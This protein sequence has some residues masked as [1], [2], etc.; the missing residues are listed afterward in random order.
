MK[1][2]LA[3]IA[4]N[5]ERYIER[6]L[7]SF[8]PHFDEVVIVRACGSLPPDRTLEIAAERGCVVGEYH[9]AEQG[10]DWPHVDDFAAARNVSFNLASGDWIMWTD[11][12]DLIDVKSMASIK[13][14]L[15][16]MPDDRDALEVAYEVPE[17]GVTVFRERVI[18][19]GAAKWVSPI[20]EHLQFPGE[21]RLA[22]ITDAK[23]VHH[24]IGARRSNDERNLR[25]LES[26][27][28]DERTASHRFHLFQSL[29]VCDRVD[30]AIAEAVDLLSGPP[31]GIGRAERFE[32]FIAVGQLSP[33]IETRSNMI[34]QALGTDPTRREAF[35]EMALCRIAAG[36]PKSALGFSRCMRAIDPPANRAWNTRGKYYGWL[37][38]QIH[39]MAL[40]ANGRMEEADTI[41]RNHFIEHGAKISLLHATRGRPRKA[42]GAR[43]AWL[44]MAADPDAIEHIFAID[45]DDQKSLPLTVHRH[46]M[47]T[48]D[49]GPVGAWNAA[50]QASR[51]EVLVQLSDDWEPFQGWDTAIL[52]AIGDTS[53]P[54]VLAVGDGTRNDDLLCMAVLTRAR[55]RDQGYL[56]HPE[57]FS[58]FS[59][60]H[61]SAE[62][63]K[64]GVVIDA[65]DRIQFE[66]VHPA[67]G[68][69]EMDATYE[70]S[71]AAHN[72]KAGAGIIRRLEN[73][74]RVSS[75]IDGWCDF[76]NF[77][78]ECATRIK[79]GSQLVE[80]G[81]WMGQSAVW[82]AQRLQDLGKSGCVLHCVDTFRGE[83]DQPAHLQ[84]VESHGGSIRAKF[85]E[86]INAADVAGMIE[87]HEGESVQRANDFG[88]ASLDFI[89]IDAAH[90]YDSV[91]ADLAA[92]FPKLKADGIFAGHDYPSDDVRRAVHEHA[93]EHGYKVVPFGRCWIKVI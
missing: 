38:E 17:D 59:D 40:R 52:D 70:H 7:N 55:Y 53:M 62:A 29:R 84:T 15:G 63:W 16:R 30:E 77:Y 87:I 33:D 13:D 50:A 35:G 74:V 21:P 67:F 47:M 19:K 83:Q 34:L 75:E 48:G 82:L 61:F 22:K 43:R 93:A 10:K 92:W 9:N 20:H 86:N 54:K 25:I 2:S 31:D 51:G 28:K 78:T 46:L 44:E 89:F 24:P 85:E 81:S 73:G 23:I 68:K 80:V 5:A 58:M 64:D 57:F 76:H 27:P 36:D 39:G 14:A 72:Y 56:F 11:L 66:H 6:F 42:A 60:N 41:E 26:I 49:Q 4:G 71:N 90:D 1:A 91:K 18:R 65:R 12:D 8:Q 88:D 3:C 69:G 45:L 37:G 79:D 32:L